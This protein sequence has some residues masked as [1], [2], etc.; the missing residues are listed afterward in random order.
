MVN[1]LEKSKHMRVRAR[2]R[3]GERSGNKLL[4]YDLRVTI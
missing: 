3:T 4:N 2:V 1:V